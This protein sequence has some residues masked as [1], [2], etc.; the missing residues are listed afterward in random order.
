MCGLKIVGSILVAV[1]LIIMAYNEEPALSIGVFI[2]TIPFV[3]LSIFY[4]RFGYYLINI[5]I[6]ISLT[7]KLIQTKQ[8][9]EADAK[10]EQ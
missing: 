6:S 7:L 2:L 8:E 3:V 9:N 5:L 4:A 1:A 10:D